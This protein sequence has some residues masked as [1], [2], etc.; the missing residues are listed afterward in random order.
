M[1]ALRRER[2]ALGVWFLVE[3]CETEGECHAGYL[4]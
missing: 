2:D 3:S 1:N 4:R